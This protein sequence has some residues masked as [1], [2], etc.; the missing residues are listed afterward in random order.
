MQ[1]L[2]ALSSLKRINAVRLWLSDAGVAVPSTARLLEALRQVFDAGADQQPSVVWGIKALRRYR[3]RLFVTEAEPPRLEDARSW[4]VA[5]GSSIELGPRLGKLIWLAQSG[6][7]ARE[8]LPAVVVVRRREGG[9]TLKPAR[10]AKMQTVQHLCQSFGVLPW[11]RDALPLVFAG[12]EL[13]AVADLWLDARWCAA[14][15][16]PGLRVAWN[17]GPAVS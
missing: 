4:P 16:A 9:E 13:I 2:R 10:L 1:G 8:K 6:G 3:D 14:A 11:M 15:H 17:N 12:D 5:P 7:L